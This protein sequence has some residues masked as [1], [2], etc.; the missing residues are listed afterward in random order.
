LV[1]SCES[2]AI[3]SVRFDSPALGMSAYRDSTRESTFGLKERILSIRLQKMA[4][5]TTASE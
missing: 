2:A 1:G 5:F 3:D 4:H